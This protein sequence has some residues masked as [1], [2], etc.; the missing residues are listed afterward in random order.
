[1]E[2]G[3]TWSISIILCL[4]SIKSVLSGSSVFPWPFSAHSQFG[5][6]TVPRTRAVEL[7]QLVVLAMSSSFVFANTWYEAVPNPRYEAL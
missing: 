7:Y 1:M 4:F 6:N 5:L 3:E 2:R